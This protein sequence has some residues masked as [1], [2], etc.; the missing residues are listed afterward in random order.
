MNNNNLM[1][2]EESKELPVQKQDEKNKI[3]KVND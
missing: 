1:K 3:I 2:I